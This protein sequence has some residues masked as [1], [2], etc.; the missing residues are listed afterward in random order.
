[1]R[2]ILINGADKTTSE[3]DVTST[4]DLVKAVGYVT[5][6]AD[7]MGAGNWVYFDEDCFL[8]GIEGRFQLD[9]LPPIA[10]N[11]VVIG[12]DG[13]VQLSATALP[14]DDLA[15]RVRYL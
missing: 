5:L 4:D 2:A 6:I 12:G 1:M 7:D 3:I 15:A 13:R 14:L 9:T 11:A 10:G 8:R